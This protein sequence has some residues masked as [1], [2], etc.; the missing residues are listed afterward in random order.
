MCTLCNT[1]YGQCH[2]TMMLAPW[3]P[4][5]LLSAFLMR[6]VFSTPCCGMDLYICPAVN[7]PEWI[8][9]TAGLFYI[10]YMA[11]I[12]CPGLPSPPFPRSYS[13]P[14]LLFSMVSGGLLPNLRVAKEKQHCFCGSYVCVIFYSLSRCMRPE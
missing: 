3:T 7:R 1:P 5:A 13:L 10:S 2:R 12:Q 8:M 9:T 4:R 11:V 6:C 14:P